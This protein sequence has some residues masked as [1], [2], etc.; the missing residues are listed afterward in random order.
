M[1]KVLELDKDFMKTYRSLAHEKYGIH[2]SQRGKYESMISANEKI[3]KFT[4]Q[5]ICDNQT[6]IVS[7]I[8]EAPIRWEVG[9]DKETEI[10]IGEQVEEIFN[11]VDN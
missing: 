5:I 3:D 1:A 7:R 4:S 11:S 6:K 2:I 8:G 9:L 10:K